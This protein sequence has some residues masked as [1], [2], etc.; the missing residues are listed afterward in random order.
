M[1]QHQLIAVDAAAFDALA[2]KID[3]LTA[4]VERLAAP[5]KREWLTVPEYAA[6]V[7]LS[8]RTIRRRIDAGTL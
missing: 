5:Q 7:G 2:A 3:R 8:T 1:T 6:A 4:T